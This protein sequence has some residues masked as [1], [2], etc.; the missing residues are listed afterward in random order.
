MQA[1][2]TLYAAWASAPPPLPASETRLS[3]R[4]SSSSGWP[5]GLRMRTLE[6][7]AGVVQ[8]SFSLGQLR[9]LSPCELEVARWANA[10]HS[11][12][13]IA[14]LRQKSIHTVVRQMANLLSKLGIG[15][16]LALATIAE[17]NA[18]SPPRLRISSHQDRALDSWL[19][20]DGL[21][22]EPVKVAHIWREI[23][24][25]NWRPLMS[26]DLDHTSHVV[27]RRISD[28]RVNWGEL[29]RVQ[30]EALALAAEG[31][32][33]K[34]IAM[35]LGLSPSTASAVMASACRRLGFPSLAQIVRA[36][37]A[38]RDA[39]DAARTA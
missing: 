7:D 12:A 1:L 25:G 23:A 4:L 37:C 19:W 24:L 31:F 39:I 21:A 20:A 17:L 16:R 14:S 32:A 2:T 15:S 26:V 5:D 33:Q 30:R 8:V 13:A 10:G 3:T 9:A 6:T 36:Y 22:V 38:A 27:M 11:N 18:W 28:R 29:N 35:K 34:A